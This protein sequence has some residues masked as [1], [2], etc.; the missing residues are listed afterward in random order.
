MRAV[1]LEVPYLIHILNN[2]MTFINTHQTL[3]SFDLFQARPRHPRTAATAAVEKRLCE[4][5]QGEAAKHAVE[6]NLWR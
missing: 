5:G 3:I 4:T 2:V 6:G 1:Q